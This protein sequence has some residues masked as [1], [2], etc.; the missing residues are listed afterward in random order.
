MMTSRRIVSLA[1]G[2]T[3]LLC[4]PLGVTASAAAWN[5]AEWVHGGVGT[6]SLRCGTDTGFEGTASGRFLSGELL[7]LDLDPIAELGRMRLA[8]A[9]SGVLTVAPADA[10]PLDPSAPTYTYANPFDVSLLSGLA[11]VSLTGLTV[12]LPGAALG[13]VNQY[14]HVSEL[15]AATGAAGLV[16]DSGAV[17]VDQ[18]TPSA[19]LPAPATISLDDLLPGVA[20]IAGAE[21][22]VGAV[23]ASAQLDGC[24]ALRSSLWGDGSVTGVIRD[25]GI[26][27]LGLQVDSPAVAGLVGIVDTTVT[28]LTAA[29]NAL[30]G[31]SSPIAAGLGA[32][33]DLALPGVLTTGIG[34][35][36]TIG[37]LDLGAA[38]A[39]LLDTPL[40]DGVVSVDLRSG[41][42]DV[43]LDALLPSLNDAPPNT[44]I[45][46]S[47]TVLAPIVTRIGTLLDNWSTQIVG[48]LTEE[49]RDVAIGIDLT[50]L[51]AAPG[52]SIPPLLT[53]PGLDVLDIDIDYTG[54]IGALLDGTAVLSLDVDAVGAVA[55]INTLLAALGLPTV[56]DL[57]GLVEGLGS[58][59][60]SNIAA[61]I[62]TTVLTLVTTLGTTLSTAINTVLASLA[63]VVNAL[64]TIVS[65]MVN[66]QPDRP[67][68][69][70][71]SVFLPPTADATGQYTV[72]ALRIGL[73]DFLV[74]GDVAHVMLGTASAGPVTAP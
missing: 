18:N 65:I 57:I 34:G 15:G 13:A 49:L 64:P 31:T 12:P 25:Y 58:A 32:R 41:A 51:V 50:A 24:A 38:V 27:G 53:L 69:P 28:N 6:S 47:A 17:L 72:S 23:G 43:D 66:V 1:V 10:I 14:A 45:V 35:N 40:T 74:P 48:A 62:T 21:L 19:A 67:G 22:R 11:G 56:T 60:V 5:D 54:T 9:G 68:A 36:V 8:L 30:R 71:G 37:G 3:A 46:L 29:V 52:I 33:L 39:T 26:A 16:N 73:A 63:G 55:P 44:E 42:V 7:G 59:L 61:T 20:G 2:A 70:P 4:V